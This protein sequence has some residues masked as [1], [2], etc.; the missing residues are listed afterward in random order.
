MQTLKIFT[1]LF[2]FTMPALLYGQWGGYTSV[3]ES[4]KASNGVITKMSVE[5]QDGQRQVRVKSRGKITINL[6]ENDLE[7]ISP[8]GWFVLEARTRQHFRRITIESN[9]RGNLSYHYAT[10]A[11]STGWG[12]KQ[13]AF[14]SRVFQEV[15]RET[16]ILSR[17]RADLIYS[18]EGEEGILREMKSIKRERS[19][20]FYC[21][22]LLDL[23]DLKPATLLAIA[24]E[25]TKFKADANIKIIVSRLIDVNQTSTLC[26]LAM[27]DAI[28]SINDEVT[29][30]NVLSD[31]SMIRRDNIAIKEAFDR[32]AY[33]IHSP[34]ERTRVLSARK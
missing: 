34:V 7:S 12:T 11:T 23:E 29:R 27:L 24:K 13:Q 14:F 3:S 16:G 25:S 31:F 4:I 21:E 33:S 2:L 9:T 15:I 10:E 30:A 26:Q 19:R 8:N 5:W 20:R 22:R 18:K 1:C 28:S 6:E 32:I 17:A